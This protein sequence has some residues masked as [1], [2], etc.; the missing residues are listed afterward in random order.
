MFRALF[1]FVVVSLLSSI[2][3]PAQEL[4][5]FIIATRRGGAVEFI[6]PTSLETVGRIHYGLP[7]KSAGLNGVSVSA[8]GT[9]LYLQAPTPDE[10]HSCCSLYSIDLA[11]LQTK[12]VGGIPGEL[13]RESFIISDGVVNRADALIAQKA[14]KGMHQWHLSADGHWLF[15]IVRFGSRG[16]DLYDFAN[17]V[18]LRRLTPTG[19][20]GNWWLNGAGAGDR[21][22]FYAVNGDGAAGR[23]WTVIAETTEL[24]NGVSLE[25]LRPSLAVVATFCW[26]DS[27]QRQAICLC[28]KCSAGSWTGAHCAIARFPA[29]RGF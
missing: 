3:L 7:P 12:L 19:L 28:M 27:Q 2:A 21:F 11:T 4:K 16:L 8:D 13:S 14:I 26:R 20:E 24:G 9:T 25:P 15:G 22:Y 17:Q 6:D 1:G 23:L 29:G 18:F 10:P 5:T